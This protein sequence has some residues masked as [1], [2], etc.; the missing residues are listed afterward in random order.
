MKRSRDTR[1]AELLRRWF[2]L[3][4]VSAYTLVG[5]VAAVAYLGVSS[6]ATRWGGLHPSVASF[7]GYAVS[8][9]ISYLGHSNV[10]FRSKAPLKRTL[11][12]F[13]IVSA[14]GFFLAAVIPGILVDHLGLA[15]DVAFLIVGAAIAGMTYGALK[16]AVFTKK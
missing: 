1:V 7:L 3:H 10:T 6:G 2:P 13:L 11:P 9:T 14:T 8:S 15:P 16:I 4:A 5:I 12:G